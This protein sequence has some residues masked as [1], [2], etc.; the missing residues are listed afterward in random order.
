LKG[1]RGGGKGNGPPPT[2]GPLL[3]RFFQKGV[4]H[5]SKKGEK[6]VVERPKNKAQKEESPG[7][8]PI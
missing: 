7:G 1:N 4:T 6:Q 5:T 3:I 8:G 2:L